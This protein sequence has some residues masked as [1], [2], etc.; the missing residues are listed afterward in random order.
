[1][2]IFY[3]LSE[4][5]LEKLPNINYFTSKSILTKS[6]PTK[7]ILPRINS[8]KAEPN[9][10]QVEIVKL[11]PIKLAKIYKFY[12]KNSF[13]IYKQ[14]MKCTKCTTTNALEKAPFEQFESSSL[15]LVTLYLCPLDMIMLNLDEK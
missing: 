4:S 13:I 2:K 12:V 7:S 15:G 1:M 6:I 9:T 3:F 11:A 8:I 5:L 14:N 10:L